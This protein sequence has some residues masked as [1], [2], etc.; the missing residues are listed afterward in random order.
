MYTVRMS[1]RRYSYLSALSRVDLH[2]DFFLGDYIVVLGVCIQRRRSTESLQHMSSHWPDFAYNIVPLGY[3]TC[4][5]IFVV[6]SCCDEVY[7]GVLEP[8]AAE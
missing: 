2:R 7:I 5:T 8:I 3:Y 1:L 4:Y 6:I